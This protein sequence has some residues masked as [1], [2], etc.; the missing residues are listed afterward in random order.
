MAFAAAKESY[1]TQKNSATEV[2][3][4][5]E[6]AEPTGFEPATSDVTGQTLSRRFS[7]KHVSCQKVREHLARPWVSR[8]AM[9]PHP[10]LAHLLA[11]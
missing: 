4:F 1:L 7:G 2:A 10:L 9:L 11:Q 6:L 5:H 8:N 3:L